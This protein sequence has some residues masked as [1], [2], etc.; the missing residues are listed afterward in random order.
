MLSYIKISN[1][2]DVEFFLNK[3]IKQNVYIT[4]IDNCREHDVFKRLKNLLEITNFDLSYENGYSRIKEEYEK[5]YKKFCDKY[6]ELTSFKFHNSEISTDMVNNYIAKYQPLTEDDKTRMRTIINL[7]EKGINQI[8]K[9]FAEITKMH[10]EQSAAKKKPPV[11]ID[12]S[13]GALG[14]NTCIDN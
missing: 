13:A 10:E 14:Q 12:L 4:D 9:D 5:V 6:E 1:D 3:G 7:V 8:E 11:K 2:N